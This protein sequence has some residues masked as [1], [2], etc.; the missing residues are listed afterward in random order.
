MKT[1][2]KIVLQHLGTL[3]RAIVVLTR[4]SRNGMHRQVL[5]ILYINL[6][7]FFIPYDSSYDVSCACSLL[8]CLCMGRFHHRTLALRSLA[9]GTDMA[10]ALVVAWA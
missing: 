4:H 7:L 8:P 5:E 10:L 9:P 6:I 3:G 1:G 2:K